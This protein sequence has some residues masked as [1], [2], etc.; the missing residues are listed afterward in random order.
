MKK[1]LVVLAILVMGGVAQAQYTEYKMVSLFIY[2]FA[3]N[4]HWPET[5]T[6]TENF[7]IGVWGN[8]QFYDEAAE[9]MKG[10]KIGSQN[11][12]VKKITDIKKINE[13]NLLFIS[14]DRNQDL[15][16]LSAAS[17]TSQVLL[18]TLQG[19]TAPN[20]P[21]INLFVDNQDHKMKFEL[22]KT[23]LNTKHLKVSKNLEDLA[24]HQ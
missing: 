17:A 15:N 1:L 20:N 19:G 24:Y 5:A 14:P 12:V 21:G 4:I 2:N 11:I 10:K 7:E 3:R 6:Q 8:S 22:K 23:A 13:C 18:I 9:Y 16:K